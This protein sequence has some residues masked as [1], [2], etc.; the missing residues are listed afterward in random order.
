MKRLTAGRLLLLDL[1]PFL[2]FLFF[3]GSVIV[4]SQSGGSDGNLYGLIGTSAALVV[5]CLQIPLHAILN[6]CQWY[7]KRLEELEEEVRRLRST[8]DLS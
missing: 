7:E 4:C 3:S 5:L 6:R 1:P 2:A 8:A